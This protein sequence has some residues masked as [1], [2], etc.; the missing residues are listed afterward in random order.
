MKTPVP[1]SQ[2]AAREASP[3]VWALSGRARSL[4]EIAVDAPRIVGVVRFT[5]QPTGVAV[6]HL[7]VW[8]TTADGWLIRIKR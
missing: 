6:T 4:Y 7:G 8:V 1:L 3:L 2:I 5:S